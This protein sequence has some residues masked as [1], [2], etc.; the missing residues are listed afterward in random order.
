MRPIHRWA[1]VGMAVLAMAVSFL[2]RQALATLGPTVCDRLGL[3]NLEFGYAAAAF[4]VAHVIG[5]P[6]AGMFLDRVGVRR[7]LL[8]AVLI[9]SAVAAAHSL[10][11]GVVSLVLLRALLGLAEAQ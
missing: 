6:L 11:A 2:D 10:A 1:L 3:S 8:A 5:A 9:W 7:G 4:S